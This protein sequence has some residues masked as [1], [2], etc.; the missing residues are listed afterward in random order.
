MCLVKLIPLL[1]MKD[2]LIVILIIIETGLEISTMPIGGNDM[3][4]FTSVI[5][6]D[7]KP[8]VCPAAV[9]RWMFERF[10]FTL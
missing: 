6:K 5:I 4:T 3:I 1:H 7:L 9:W 10:Q 8:A 2:K